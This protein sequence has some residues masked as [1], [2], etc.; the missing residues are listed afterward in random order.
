MMTC[1]LYEGKMVYIDSNSS[2]PNDEHERSL[3]GDGHLNKLSD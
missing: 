3:F 1:K 2:Y